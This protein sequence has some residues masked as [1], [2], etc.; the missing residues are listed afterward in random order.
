VSAAVDTPFFGRRL[1]THSFRLLAWARPYCD[2]V[3]V[4]RAVGTND[5]GVVV[6]SL[7]LRTPEWPHGRHAIAVANDITFAAGAFGPREHAMFRAAADLSIRRQ[8]PLLYLAANSGAKVGLDQKLKQ[9]MQVC[10]A[11]SVQQRLAFC[12]CFVST[13]AHTGAS[14]VARGFVLFWRSLLHAAAAP[15]P[16]ML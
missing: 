1:N 14:C 8:L 12:S 4:T 6:W 2:L 10:G 11:Q 9:L 16:A 5:V 3:Q 13:S 15:S 7:L